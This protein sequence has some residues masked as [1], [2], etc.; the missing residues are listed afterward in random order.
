MSFNHLKRLAVTV[1]MTAEFPLHQ[2]IG[3]PVLILA[4]ATSANKD[5]FNGLLRR[6][7]KNLRQIQAQSI[8]TSLLDENREDDRILYS[9]HVVKGWRK[10]VDDT[11]SLVE[12]NEASCLEFLK[13]LP[14]WLFDDVRTFASNPRNFLDD[15]PDEEVT[16]GNLPQG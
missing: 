12:L 11:G 4:P 14:D 3:E 16:A 15:L 13:A 6:S 5:Y 1:E 2:L 8:D 9:K 10:I 7:R